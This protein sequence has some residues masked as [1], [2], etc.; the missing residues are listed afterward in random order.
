MPSKSNISTSTPNPGTRTPETVTVMLDEAGL[1]TI[2]S[3]EKREP[4]LRNCVS[5][6]V[7]QP[8]VSVNDWLDP[9]IERQFGVEFEIV[10]FVRVIAVEIVSV[11][12]ARQTTFAINVSDEIEK[13]GGSVN[14]IHTPSESICRGAAVAPIDD[15][16]DSGVSKS[17]RISIRN[18]MLPPVTGPVLEA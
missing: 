4:V 9:P 1:G 3:M 8:G 2:L 18:V 7:P 10:A 17:V 11:T 13:V 16:T 5:S 12:K 15:M 14:I 6:V